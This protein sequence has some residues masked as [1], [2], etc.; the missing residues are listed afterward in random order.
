[1][2]DVAKLLASKSG[3]SV[4]YH[5]GLMVQDMLAAHGEP[6]VSSRS[7]ASDADTSGLVVTTEVQKI[8]KR[9]RSSTVNSKRKDDGGSD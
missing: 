7:D 8:E 4:K 9:G 2:H 1:M 6:A 3:R 5:R